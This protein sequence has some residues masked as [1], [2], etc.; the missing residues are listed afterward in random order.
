[1][2]YTYFPKR[3]L[4]RAAVCNCGTPWT[5]LLPFFF[6]IVRLSLLTMTSL[7]QIRGASVF[8]FLFFFFVVF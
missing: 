1:M 3:G 8:F 4:E 5:F 7:N 6:I 2:D